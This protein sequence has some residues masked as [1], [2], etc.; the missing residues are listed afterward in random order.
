MCRCQID[1]LSACLR[2][3]SLPNCRLS[4]VLGWGIAIVIHCLHSWESCFLNLQRVLRVWDG[5]VKICYTFCILWLP[6]RAT[7]KI[8][9]PAQ[10]RVNPANF[11]FARTIS[12]WDILRKVE[13]QSINA[14]L[15]Q[16]L[17]KVHVRS[18]RFCRQPVRALWRLVHTG[19]LIH[20]A[21]CIAVVHPRRL[22][23][24]EA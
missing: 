12:A 1:R 4:K 10:Y 5:D 23:R 21:G 19:A 18:A 17:M 20:K 15:R 24:E 22:L 9:H 3:L 2:K 6:P 14:C 8:S 16:Y 7:Q 11:F 13:S